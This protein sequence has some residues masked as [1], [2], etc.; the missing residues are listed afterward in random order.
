MFRSGTA[1]PPATIEVR[2]ADAPAADLIGTHKSEREETNNNEG[3]APSHGRACRPL[4]RG[5][6]AGVAKH[7]SSRT[8][9]GFTRGASSSRLNAG[10]GREETTAPPPSVGRPKQA[11]RASG[12]AP[13]FGLA[14]A[15]VRPVFRQCNTA[16]AKLKEHI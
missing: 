11:M 10:H 13:I 7:A 4:R 6:G 16:P 12:Q 2:A 9:A 1:F 15:I 8:H 14:A 5:R 3:F